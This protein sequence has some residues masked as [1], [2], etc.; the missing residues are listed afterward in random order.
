VLDFVKNRFDLAHG[1][2]LPKRRLLWRRHRVGHHE[3][4]LQGNILAIS[5]HVD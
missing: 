5:N 3:Q 2:C 1:S 4:V